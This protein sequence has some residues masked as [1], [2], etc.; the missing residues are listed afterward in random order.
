M[1]GRRAQMKNVGATRRGWIVLLAMITF[2]FA[3]GPGIFL[4][5]LEAGPSS[6]PNPALPKHGKVVVITYQGE[7]YEPPSRTPKI[8][9]ELR[10]QN[11]RLAVH[12]GDTIRICN[13]RNVYCRPFSLSAGNRFGQKANTP[14]GDTVILAPGKCY[15]FV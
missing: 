5:R 14:K 3:L 6:A 4:E 1:L 10:E 11:A 13:A 2:S 9:P 15:D 12:A 7:R 8:P